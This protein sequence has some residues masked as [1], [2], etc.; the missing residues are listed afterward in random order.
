MQNTSTSRSTDFR[1]QK[2]ITSKTPL[3]LYGR[4]SVQVT[5]PRRRPVR[6]PGPSQIKMHG[7]CRLFRAMPGI[8]GSYATVNFKLNPFKAISASEKK[9]IDLK[10]EKSDFLK[11]TW[12]KIEASFDVLRNR[13]EVNCSLHDVQTHQQAVGH[14][15]YRGNNPNTEAPQTV[16]YMRRRALTKQQKSSDACTDV[17]K[18]DDCERSDDDDG[19]FLGLSGVSLNWREHRESA[20]Q[21]DKK[22]RSYPE[23]FKRHLATFNESW[24]FCGVEYVDVICDV[25]I[26]SHH[27]R[28]RYQE[29]DT[30]E[31]CT[32]TAGQPDQ[33]R[34]KRGAE[35]HH[36]SGDSSAYQHPLQVRQRMRCHDGKCFHRQ[37]QTRHARP[38]ARHP[39]RHLYNSLGHGSV[40]FHGDSAVRFRLLR[41]STVVFLRP[42][43]LKRIPAFTKYYPSIAEG[44][45]YGD[46]ECQTG[47]EPSQSEGVR[48]YHSVDNDGDEKEHRHGKTE[49]F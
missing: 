2:T 20:E 25:R 43:S 33:P 21:E 12:S 6:R 5:E 10:I 29:D 7:F 40:G 17:Q 45:S 14:L 27:V 31:K 23:R 28:Q 32:G 11:L 35:Q 49:K 36:G 48:S 13:D 24:V 30:R 3:T 42:A 39:H 4:D 47:H 16:G 34:V 18:P 19:P 37:K 44:R 9:H 15:R 22:W 38:E 41:P 46:H 26:T 1:R 8:S